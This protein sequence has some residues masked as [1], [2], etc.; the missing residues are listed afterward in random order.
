MPFRSNERGIYI[1]G[2]IKYAVEMGSDA[3]I[4]IQSFTKIGSSIQKMI[5][6]INRHIDSTEIA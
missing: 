6:G 1:E 2:F 4:Y 3:I 5:G